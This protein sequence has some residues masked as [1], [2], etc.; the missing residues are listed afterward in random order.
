MARLN[1]VAG[2]VYGSD[3]RVLITERL[4]DGP[5]HG[6]WEFPGGK[7]ATGETPQFALRRELREEI[8]ISVRRCQSF[9]QVRHDYPDRQVNLHFFKVFD[10]SGVPSGVEGQSL[11]W[12]EPAEI[13]VDEMLPADAPVIRALRGDPATGD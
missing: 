3:R 4:D 6:L 5:F 10:W 8:G 7:I 2:I 13:A 11:R 9:M 12:L 1:V